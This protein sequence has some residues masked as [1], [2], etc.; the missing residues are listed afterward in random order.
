MT[1][2]YSKEIREPNDCPPNSIPLNKRY[3]E[4][5]GGNDGNDREL[6][7][8]RIM[9]R[10]RTLSF[11]E[12]RRKQVA[13]LPKL[14]S[15]ATLGRNS[16][17]HHLSPTDRE[18]LGGAEYKALKL[19]LKVALSYFF[20]LHFMGIICLVPWIHHSPDK[21]TDYLQEVGQDRTWWYAIPME[22]SLTMQHGLT[23]LQQG[24]VLCG[25]DDQ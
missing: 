15:Q 14:S 6:G 23:Y 13:A 19:L 9:S 10:S 16:S 12:P 21:Y 20:G 17:F 7:L 1:D 4:S 2:C 24:L 8:R 25:N 18:T 11:S 5:T 22:S 3:A